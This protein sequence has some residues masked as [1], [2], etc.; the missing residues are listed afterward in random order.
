[1]SLR[2]KAERALGP[3]P[4]PQAREIL[5]ATPSDASSICLPYHLIQDWSALEETE[6]LDGSEALTIF[7][8]TPRS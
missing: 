8:T 6:F 3:R 2:K 1:M 7:S 5:R 4:G